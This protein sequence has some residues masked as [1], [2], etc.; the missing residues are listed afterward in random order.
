MVR[1]EAEESLYVNPGVRVPIWVFLRKDRGIDSPGSDEEI[2]RSQGRKVV[3]MGDEYQP[4]LQ[5]TF[6]FD[7]GDGRAKLTVNGPK[8]PVLGV[9]A[10]I[11]VSRDAHGKYHF[12]IGVNDFVYEPKDLPDEL[13]KLLG[14]PHTPAK[15]PPVPVRMPSKS[16][17]Q[18]SDGT[19][20]TWDDYDRN[21]RMFYSPGMNVGT[22]WP[23][24]P[25]GL[26]QA[27]INFYSG[28]SSWTFAPSE[29]GDFPIPTGDTR[30]G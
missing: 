10:A 21:R 24:L 15:G 26:Y 29:V 11:G 25:P 18:R 2:E 4:Y 6:E 8:D 9:S 30:L 12:L 5:L 20:M 23:P 3:S 17:L 1:R 28:K 27:L 16:Q 14:D 13:R 19:F 22:I 7:S